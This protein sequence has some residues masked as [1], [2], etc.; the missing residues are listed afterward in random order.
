ML[1]LRSVRAIDQ[2]RLK[3]HWNIALHNYGILL[4]QFDA[5]FIFHIIMF[6]EK[7]ERKISKV[8]GVAGFA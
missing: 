7:A 1:G 2:K 4:K 5:S 3:R 8:E 6:E